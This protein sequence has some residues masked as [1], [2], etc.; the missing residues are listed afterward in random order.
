[1]SC[2]SFIKND[3]WL[4]SMLAK[5]DNCSTHSSAEDMVRVDTRLRSVVLKVEAITLVLISSVRG[6]E[7]LNF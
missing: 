4:A 1:M 7:Y 3:W 5:S 6:A 2:I